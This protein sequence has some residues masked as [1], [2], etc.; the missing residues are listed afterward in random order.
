MY[1]DIVK[2]TILIQRS[3]NCFGLINW[4]AHIVPSINLL[5]RKKATESGFAFKVFPAE[6]K[7]KL[8]PQFGSGDGR[9]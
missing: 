8:P 7:G 2:T 6:K 5:S 4:H 9:F 3:G 1:D